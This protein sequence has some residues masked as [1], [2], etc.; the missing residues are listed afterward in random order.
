MID[1]AGNGDAIARRFRGVAL[2]LVCIL[3][4]CAERPGPEVLNP[5]PLSIPGAKVVTVYVAT[6]RAREIPDSNIYGSARAHHTNYAE[7]KISIPPRHQSGNIEWPTGSPDP[8]LSFT[9][10]QQN[11]L[12]SREF[13]Q[14]IASRANG[15][16]RLNAGVFVH[17][18]NTNFQEALYRLAQMTADADVDGTPIL[19]TW[20]SEARVTGYLSDK[21]GVTY[22]RDRLVDLLAML[23]RKPSIG[24]VTVIGHSMGSW[25]TVEALRQ[26]RLTRSDAVINRLNVVLAAPDIDV[27]VFRSQMEVIGPLSPPMTVLVS[28]DDIALRLSSKVAGGR[29]RLGTLDVDDPRVQEAA[30]RANVQ[31]V[32]ISSLKA[33]DGLNHDRFVNLAALYGRLAASGSNHPDKNLRQAGAFVFNTVGTTLSSPF[34]L[35]GSAIA[36]E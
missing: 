25:L 19:F 9:T 2:A 35:V 8:A 4:G 16:G 23:A 27:D 33:P 3:G 11:V 26:L 6:T 5:V 7:F 30:R 12:S 36:G 21:E 22:S 24:R 14:A 10:I 1:L 17:G 32:D 28:R 13:E 20:P 31:I 15:R 29:E 34:S 18:F